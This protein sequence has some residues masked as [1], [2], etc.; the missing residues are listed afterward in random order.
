MAKIAFY[1]KLAE[2]LGREVEIDLPP[3]GCEIAALRARFGGLDRATVR[4]CV[5]DEIAVEDHVVKPGDRVD[6]L[7][8]L[9]G[10]EV[11]IEAR[12]AQGR[13]SQSGSWRALRRGRR[14]RGELHCSP[15]PRPGTA[16]RWSGSISIIIR[17][18]PNGR[19][20]RSPRR[21]RFG[22]AA[23][24]IVHR[25]GEIDSGRGESCSSPPPRFTAAPLSTWSTI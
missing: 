10:D 25:C 16:R 12:L 2:R 21:R 20:G 3:E 5:N 1:G 8:P 23:V 7:P 9:A 22:V 13:F 11:E 14:R 18:S 24:R 4:A 19:C 15:G 6:F 17:G